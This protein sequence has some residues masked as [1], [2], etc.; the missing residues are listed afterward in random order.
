MA[1]AGPWWLIKTAENLSRAGPAG[2]M[3]LLARHRV[4]RIGLGAAG[5]TA[6]VPAAAGNGT[7]LTATCPAGPS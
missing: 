5:Q 4:V 6:H 2:A 3:Y 1:A 7:V